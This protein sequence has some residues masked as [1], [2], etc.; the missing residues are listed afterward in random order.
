MNLLGRVCGCEFSREVGEVGE[1]EL[2]RVGGVADAEEDDV[3]IDEVVEGIGASI[4]ASLRLRGAGK[5]AK[6]LPDLSFD[7]GQGSFRLLV[8]DRCAEHQACGTVF[9]SVTCL[10]NGSEP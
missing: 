5:F 9:R 8:V 10:A 2:A 1:G 6:N 3:G 4:D 7:F